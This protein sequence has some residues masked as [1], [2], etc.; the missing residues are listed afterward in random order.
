M[1]YPKPGPRC[2]AHA[3]QRV[4][5]RKRA[6]QQNPTERNLQALRVAQE[7]FLTTPRGLKM[8]EEQS[9]S[10][11]SARILLEIKRAQREDALNKWKHAQ[12]VSE[13]NTTRDGMMN[14]SLNA[15]IG[16][17]G[18]KPQW[19][20]QYE[21]ECANSSIQTKPE[22]LDVFP[23]PHGDIAVVWEPR[24]QHPGDKHVQREGWG[25]NRCSFFNV[26]TGQIM[27]SVRV[28]RFSDETLA[29]SYGNDEASLFRYRNANMG[30]TLPSLRKLDDESVSFGS[31]KRDL[32]KDLLRYRGAT[33][34]TNSGECVTHSNFDEIV[35]NE[36]E[37]I[38][39]VIEAN[40]LDAIRHQ[41]GIK[42]KLSLPYVDY[43]VV[44]DEF[45][46]QGFGSPLYVYTARRL[47]KDGDALRASSLQSDEAQSLWR[48][49]E[50][51]IGSRIKKVG[52]GEDERV[53][54][55]FR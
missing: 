2:S 48:R 11:D 14:H 16:Y 3:Q 24:S 19:W 4:D 23:S 47:A 37:V 52:E 55:D 40:K 38:D 9:K 22:L 36:P 54:L 44:E 12:E 10:D 31:I 5:A 53:F 50:Q 32:V 46:G 43:S 27:G 6:Y 20:E 7:E 42:E 33:V 45:R 49:L 25:L 21:A 15:P 8:L 51:R 13:G 29:E 26:E 34:T 17:K 28:N 30:Y 39:R 1:C 18:E 41:N 35:E